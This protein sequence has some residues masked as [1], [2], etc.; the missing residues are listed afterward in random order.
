[1]AQIRYIVLDVEQSIEFYTSKLGFELKQQFGVAMAI[2]SFGDIELWL[3]GPKASASKPMPDGAKPLPGG[4]ARFVLPVANLDELATRLL[5]EGVDFRSEIVVG[6]VV[7]Q[8]LCV[9][10]SGNV[11]ELFE[12]SG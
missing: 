11:V 8:A 1:M 5:S 7:K 4:W 3:A 10:P 12:T 9:D 2:V 6:P